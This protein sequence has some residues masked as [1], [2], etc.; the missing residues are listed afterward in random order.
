MEITFQT[1]KLHGTFESERNL[2]KEFVSEIAKAIMRRM[3]VLK[4]AP[5]L[6]DV[7]HR[8]PERR[9]ALAGD[10]QGQFAVD[11]K[12]PYRLIFQPAHD[13]LPLKDDGGIDLRRVTAIIIIEVEDYH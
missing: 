3:A 13:P 4:A 1:K 12:H 7:S 2:R 6:E 10:R 11:L 9:H 5:C 8:P